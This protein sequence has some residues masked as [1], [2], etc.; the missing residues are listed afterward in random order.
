MSWL[1]DIFLFDVMVLVATLQYATAKRQ[2]QLANDKDNDNQ[3]HL[4]SIVTKEGNETQ[5]SNLS[6]RPVDYHKVL[7]PISEFRPLNFKTIAKNLLKTT[8]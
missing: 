2:S 4:G 8:F 7:S 3:F 1:T 5:Q 6:Q